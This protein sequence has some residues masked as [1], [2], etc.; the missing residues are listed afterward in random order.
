VKPCHVTASCTDCRAPLTSPDELESGLCLHCLNGPVPVTAPVPDPGALLD[1]LEEA[2]AATLG[3]NPSAW[4]NAASVVALPEV[5]GLI[6]LARDG[7]ALETGPLVRALDQAID[8]YEALRA[9]V[10]RLA[11]E[12]QAEGE[13]LQ[14]R[15][16]R[17]A[18]VDGQRA[19]D[20]AARLRKLTRAR[21]RADVADT[22][23]ERQ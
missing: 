1:R 21:L 19:L 12:F 2:V 20:D 11:E 15:S 18:W 7:L 17:V 3:G 4:R 9:G 23:G 6:R 16:R 5:A 10:E 22:S 13:E 14:T 8:R